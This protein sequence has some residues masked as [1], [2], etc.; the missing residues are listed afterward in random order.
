MT[1]TPIN[2]HC[3]IKRI[4]G[5]ALTLDKSTFIRDHILSS[6]PENEIIN[7]IGKKLIENYRTEYSLKIILTDTL[8]HKF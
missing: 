6:E 3:D 7:K 4:R 8:H 1:A 5:E 2:R